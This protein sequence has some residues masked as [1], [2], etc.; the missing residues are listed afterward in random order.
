MKQN[1]DLRVSVVIPAHNEQDYLVAC[2]D[3]LQKQTVACYEIIV[4]DNASTD[5]TADIARSFPNVTVISE[6]RLGV[7][8]ARTTGFN[9]ANGD[10][11]ARSDADCH[12]DADWV[13]RI[14]QHFALHH[15]TAAITG[16]FAYYDLPAQN[17]CKKLENTMRTKLYQ[18]ADH[19]CFLAGAN[20]AL[21][22]EVWQEVRT[23]LCQSETLHEDL[24]IAIHLNELN[25]GITFDS[26]LNVMTSA[27]RLNTR[28]KDFY[29]YM[30]MYEHTYNMHNIHS[31]TLKVPLIA[32]F[33]LYPIARTAHYF[34]SS[35]P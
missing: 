24:D 35:A 20:M 9:H 34:Y 3:S 32:Y 27:R 6:K 30:K 28:T 23:I 12:I 13:E 19:P 1:K 25:H 33:S 10:I 4:V 21:R 2:L 15:E 11:I 22:R 31:P 26:K 7:L 16:P 29:T 18:H 17:I 8:H 14:Q 5:R